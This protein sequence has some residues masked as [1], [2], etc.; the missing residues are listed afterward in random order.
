MSVVMGGLLFVYGVALAV[1][2][3]NVN[4]VMKKSLL[5]QSALVESEERLRTIFDNVPAA[6][7]LKDAEGRYKFIN[8][9]YAE[10]FEIDPATV[11]GRTVHDMFPAERADRYRAGDNRILKT[12]STVSEEVEIPLPSG[13][14]RTFALTKFP[15]MNGRELTDIGGVMIDITERRTAEIAMREKTGILEATMK[16]I[17]DGL[18]VLDRDMNLVAW[19][20]QLF[21]VLDLDKKKILEADDPGKA[22]RYASADRGAYGS[23]DR[24]ELVASRE[25]ITRM[26][27]GVQ[28]ERELDNGSWIECRGLPIEEDEGWVAVFRDVSERRKLERMKNE[29]VTTVS[30][31]LRTPL[32]SIYGS[33]GLVRDSTIGNLPGEAQHL[34][35]IAHK[36]CAR[37]VDLV[38]DILDV[39]KIEAGKLEYSMAPVSIRELIDDA[40]EANEAYGAQFGVT[41][42]V[43]GDIPNLTVTADYRKLLQVMANLLSNASKHSPDGSRVA[44]SVTQKASAAIV[45]VRDR[46]NG[47]PEEYHDVIFDKFSKI[48]SPDSQSVR[49]T[50]LG[51]SICRSI[52]DH[53]DGEI[54]FVSL[55]ANLT[56]T[57][58]PLGITV[59]RWR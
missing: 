56:E 30:H 10:W 33:L 53:H 59:G 9:R 28:F 34:I 58:A 14:T 54:Y 38:N 39:G 47:I 17:P 43:S 42:E 23:G 11:D 51:L 35:E 1:L 13:E 2:A 18:Q 50:G 6:I 4:R 24:N 31:E 52:I 7:F 21:T 55:S 29:F 48:A 46:G 16:T 45:A 27:D 36:N 26:R 32:T 49:G 8:A 3:H 12:L 19:N 40:M 57:P 25:N 41:F 22:F 5:L 15:I 44:I 37:L 20:D